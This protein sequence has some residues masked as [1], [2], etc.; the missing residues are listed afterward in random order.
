MNDKQ[1]YL[2]QIDKYYKGILKSNQIIQVCTTP[3]YLQKLGAKP[4][5]I[6]MKQTTLAKCIR[7]PRGS[8]SAHNLD[9][10][11]HNNERN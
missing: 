11:M 4:L 10:V 6:V 1:S 3:E 8:R 7:T 9:R 2:E 5:P